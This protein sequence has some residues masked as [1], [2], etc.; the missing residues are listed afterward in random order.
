MAIG[1][2]AKLSEA[3]R[4]CNQAKTLVDCS[5]CDYNVARSLRLVTLERLIP[6][7]ERPNCIQAISIIATIEDTFFLNCTATN[8]G[9]AGWFKCFIN[10]TSGKVQRKQ[11]L[12]WLKRPYIHQQVNGL[13]KL[14]LPSP[15]FR[16]RFSPI[17]ELRFP[18]SFPHL[19]P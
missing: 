17:T 2:L 6:V 15:S 10:F 18:A 13:M 12:G 7:N 3:Q 14:A 8:C 19:A 16:S 11:N 4:A 9:D 5:A 1:K